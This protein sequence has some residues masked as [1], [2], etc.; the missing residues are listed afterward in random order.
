M[1]GVGKNNGVGRAAAVVM[2]T[3]LLFGSAACGGSGETDGDGSGGKAKAA[4]SGAGPRATGGATPA[5]GTATA[6]A[7]DGTPS[8]AG[9]AGPDA[10]RLKGLVLA[11]GEKAGPY[12]AD[13]ALL[14]EPFDEIYDA[15]P[16]V[17]QPLTG[18]GRAG[19]TAQAYVPVSVPDEV[20]GVD[21][22]VQLRSYK[23]AGAA[24]SVMKSLA[25]AGRRCAAGYTEERTVVD[26]KVLRVEPVPAPKLGDEAQAYRIV[27]Q[28][29]KDKNASL[30]TY[31]TL[32]RSDAVTLSFRSEMLGVDD[33][34]GVPGE[35]VTA[36]WEKFS[37]GVAAR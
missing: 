23:D 15:S 28:D 13:L 19:H 26:A 2:G 7:P 1:R 18:L 27:V 5:G 32:V 34:G 17:C 6:S 9:T 4:A 20:L 37:R 29:V 16:A 25:E 36:Q 8:P 30:Y 24:G 33:F 21:T 11:L 14:D 31:L 12:E 10:E 3:A 22:D 35:I